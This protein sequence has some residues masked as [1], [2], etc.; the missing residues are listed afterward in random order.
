MNK[1]LCPICGASLMKEEKRFICK[2]NHNFDQAKSGYVNLLINR[3]ASGD[4]LEMVQARRLILEKGYFEPIRQ[5]CVALFLK[6]GIS[7][8]LDVGCGEGYYTK[9]LAANTLESYGVDISKQACDY[10]AKSDKKTQY[11]VASA[12]QLPFTAHS[13][14]AVIHLFAMHHREFSR[15]AANYIL[16][17]VPNP[18]HLLELKQDLY[19]EVYVHQKEE[20]DFPDFS[21]HSVDRI[22]YTVFVEEITSLVKMTPYF[23][24]SNWQNW[25]H[26][27]PINLTIDVSIYLF[28]RMDKGA[29]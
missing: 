16:S 13:V 23:Y 22:T 8:F 20:P 25:N 15:V 1:L 28:K 6:H 7:S 17:V 27:K 26:L 12:S 3:P 9:E 18:D 5:H 14:D 11:I 29:L 10:A 21:I 24:T 19:D 4:N 2:N